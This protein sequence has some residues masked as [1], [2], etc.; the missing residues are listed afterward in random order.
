MFVF[1]K[2]QWITVISILH[3]DINRLQTLPEYYLG[4]TETSKS[5]NKS[6]FL[7]IWTILKGIERPSRRRGKGRSTTLYFIT[8]I[9][10]ALDEK[11]KTH[12]KTLLFT[13]CFI[14][15]LIIA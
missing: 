7:N 6:K 3:T 11:T 8:N 10:A 13:P 5:T 2:V 15:A 4:Q 12:S 14:M 1:D 9:E